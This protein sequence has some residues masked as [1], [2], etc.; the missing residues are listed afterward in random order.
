MRWT[1]SEYCDY[2]PSFLYRRID[3]C[4]IFSVCVITNHLCCFFEKKK[5]VLPNLKIVTRISLAA[6]TRNGVKQV[7]N[8][9]VVLQDGRLHGVNLPP[10]RVNLL[11]H[12]SNLAHH[13]R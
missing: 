7:V 9:R 13:V 2:F 4:C 10:K 1:A 5:S 8:L 12:L 11:L 6:T 3:L